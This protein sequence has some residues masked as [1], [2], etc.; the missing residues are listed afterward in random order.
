[1]R[2]KSNPAPSGLALPAPLTEGVMAAALKELPEGT[3]RATEACLKCYRERKFTAVDL[4]CYIQSISAQSPTLTGLGPLNGNM[5][6]QTAKAPKAPFRSGPA[7]NSMP[8]ARPNFVRQPPSAQAIEDTRFEKTEQAVDMTAKLIERRRREVRRRQFD[9][10]PGGQQEKIGNYVSSVIRRLASLV[11]TEGKVMLR[12]AVSSYAS[13]STTPEQFVESMQAIVDQYSI[14]VSL[15][16][17]PEHETRAAQRPGN[18]SSKRSNSGQSQAARKRARPDVAASSLPAIEVSSGSSCSTNSPSSPIDVNPREWKAE[19]ELPDGPVSSSELADTPLGAFLTNR[20]AAESLPERNVAVK[21]VSQVMSYTGSGG[22]VQPYRCKSIFAFHNLDQNGEVVLL[23]MYVH[24]FGPESPPETAGRVL[25]ECIDSIPIHG[26]ETSEERQRLLSAIVHGY[27]EYVRTQGFTHI[28]FRVPPPSAEN[29]HIFTSRSLSVRLEAT[30]RMAHWYRRLLEGAHSKGLVHKYELQSHLSRIE[31][32]PPALLPSSDLA[33]EHAFSTM[34]SQL[35]RSIQSGQRQEADVKLFEKL[36]SFRDRFCVASLH[37]PEA[38]TPALRVDTSPTMNTQICAKRLT[39]VLGC[40][41]ENLSFGTLADAKMSTMLL[42]ARM[43]SDQRESTSFVMPQTEVET[44]EVLMQFS[45]SEQ[46]PVSTEQG[47][48]RDC[49]SGENG[50]SSSSDS[51]SM[52][53]SMSNC[54]TVQMSHTPSWAAKS[55]DS[56]SGSFDFPKTR[57][58]DLMK[59]NSFDLMQNEVNNMGGLQGGCGPFEGAGAT[60]G[61]DA[62]LFADSLFEV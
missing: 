35:S 17:S 31:S 61:L 51:N 36:I 57:S 23:G 49:G 39:F 56:H 30:V 18:H 14:T 62:E 11:P 20:A 24:E 21:V 55:I 7:P 6:Q 46:R 43:I 1:L 28:H 59:N 60:S 26:N 29:H 13:Q 12:D 2:K 4:T 33:E 27:I 5:Q 45:H 54:G 15:E 38:D 40:K 19:G 37:H 41:R 42:L 32:F 52:S 9:A 16:Y 10:Y 25:I 58:F 44:P 8:A 3:R 48:T 47:S 22:N 53:S 34:R 50:C